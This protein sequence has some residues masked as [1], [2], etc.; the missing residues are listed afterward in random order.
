MYYVVC[1]GFEHG[2]READIGGVQLV[3]RGVLEVISLLNLLHC[4]NSTLL[5]VQWNADTYDWNMYL[6]NW[7]T[8]KPPTKNILLCFAYMLVI[9]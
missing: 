8:L 3:K 6:S 4:N 2:S 9:K 1:R 5:N 7:S